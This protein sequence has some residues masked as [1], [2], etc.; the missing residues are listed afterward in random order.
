MRK[1]TKILLVTLFVLILLTSVGVYMLNKI[2]QELNVLTTKSIP[3]IDLMQLKDGTYFGS[4][5]SLVIKVSVEVTIQNHVI[6]DIVILE[7]QNGQGDDAEI[8]IDDV[9]L[10][11][12]MDIDL[13]SGATYSSRAILLAI[14]D[15]LS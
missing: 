15:A 11:Q 8:I 12:S 7:H 6:T 10:E 3:K 4:Y 13:I 2:N 1:R 5:D 14:G 9:I